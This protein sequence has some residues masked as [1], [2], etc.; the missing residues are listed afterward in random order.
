M[1]ERKYYP[2][3]DYLMVS[4]Y[5]DGHTPK[6]YMQL[7]YECGG[8]LVFSKEV[9]KKLFNLIGRFLKGDV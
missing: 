6:E 9:C 1:V 4:F 5:R 8:S 3:T 7:N 2:I